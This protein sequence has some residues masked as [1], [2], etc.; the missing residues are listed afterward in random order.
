MLCLIT[1]QYIELYVFAAMHHRITLIMENH[2]FI[3]I[4]RLVILTAYMHYKNQYVVFYNNIMSLILLQPFSNQPHYSIGLLIGLRYT[5]LM[6]NRIVSLNA[7]IYGL[8]LYRPALY[9]IKELLDC[10]KGL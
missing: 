1:M 8:S 2:V 6:R 10:A 7:H 3:Y 4:K 5:H 9:P